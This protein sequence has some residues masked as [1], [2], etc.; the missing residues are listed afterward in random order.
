MSHARRRAL[1]VAAVGVVAAGLVVSRGH[2]LAADLGGGALYAALLY[3]LVALAVPR[4]RSWRVGL[5]A[6][7]LSVAVELLQL[8]DLPRDVVAQVPVARYV[9]GTT[10]VAT[11]LLAYAVGAALA[12]AADV[13]LRRRVG[14][15]SGRD[16]RPA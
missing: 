11:D 8:T 15:L 2:G 16:R 9:L 12:T 3:V 7:A 13:V 14:A 5:A 1:A 4:A 10:F 6:L